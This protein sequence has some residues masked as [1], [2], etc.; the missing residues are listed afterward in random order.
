M[1]TP[2]AKNAHPTDLSLK[3]IGGENV[4]G[5]TVTISKSP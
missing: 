3:G 2:F 1:H 4:T 5:S